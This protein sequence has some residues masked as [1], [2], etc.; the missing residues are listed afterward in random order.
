[1]SQTE[2]SK[3]PTIIKKNQNLSYV[4]IMNIDRYTAVD[5]VSTEM[6]QLTLETLCKNIKTLSSDEHKEIY[7]VARK[8]KPYSF[9]TVSNGGTHFNISKI[10]NHGLW[11][12]HRYVYLSLENKQR[13][14]LFNKYEL[15]AL[16]EIISPLISA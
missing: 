9:F 5:I 2:S 14:E 11:E 10:S 15:E 1:M 3:K 13:Q 6:D 8:Y 16:G 12:I 4:P 7:L